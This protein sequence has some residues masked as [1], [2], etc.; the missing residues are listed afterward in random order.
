MYKINSLIDFLSQHDI[1]AT[2][3][4]EGPGLRDGL[5]FVAKTTYELK[6]NDLI[7]VDQLKGP[8]VKVLFKLP[9]PLSDSLTHD[10]TAW[11][12]PYAYGINAI[13]SET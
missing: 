2:S 3:P 12:L 7:V 8:M 6:S 1:E 4:K 9:R 11:S 5:C 10:I 13:A